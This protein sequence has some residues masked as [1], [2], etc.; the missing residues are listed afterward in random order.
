MISYIYKQTRLC[1]LS[2]NICKHNIWLNISIPYHTIPYYPAIWYH[3]V[4]YHIIYHPFVKLTPWKKKVSWDNWSLENVA[5]PCDSMVNRHD[6][7]SSLM[8]ELKSFAINSLPC[9]ISSLWKPSIP[10][11]EIIK[12]LILITATLT[13]YYHTLIYYPRFGSHTYK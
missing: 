10:P 3:T 1:K 13:L 11:L 7:L 8:L 9:K 5:T 4:P 6:Q 2:D 12:M